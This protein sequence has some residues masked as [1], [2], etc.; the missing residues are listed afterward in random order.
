M[1][2]R[3]S[4]AAETRAEA[5]AA[6]ARRLLEAPEIAA[7]RRVA[8]YVSLGAEPPTGA[9]LAQL[10]QRGVEVLVP[11]LRADLDLGWAELTGETGLERGLRGT[12]QPADSAVLDPAAVVSVD[13]VVCPGLAVDPSGVRLGRGGG[14][15]DRALARVGPGTWTCVLL[16]DDEVLA[17][18]L[19]REEHD[20]H[21]RA[22]V[23]P[24][25]LVR[26]A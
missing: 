15:Y 7:A 3:R 26:F 10:R 21:V 4:I 25:R 12:L 13:A 20:R 2:R 17:D 14:S 22:A 6:I 9:L 23:T 24:R 1:A 19:P 18:R 8:A 5:G 16:Y 11:V